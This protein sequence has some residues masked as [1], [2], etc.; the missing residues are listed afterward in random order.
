MRL[1][2]RWVFFS[3][4]ALV[5]FCLAPPHIN[6]GWISKSVYMPKAAAVVVVREV[7]EVVPV[8]EEPAVPVEVVAVLAREEPAVVREVAEEPA[9][10]VVLAVT[11]PLLPSMRKRFAPSCTAL[12]RYT[13]LRRRTTRS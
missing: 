7:A 12:R 6:D 3:T 11:M 4:A 2:P 5:L 8:M 10:A 13:P 9:V 1:F